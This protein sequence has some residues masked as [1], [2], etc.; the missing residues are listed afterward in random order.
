MK[1]NGIWTGI[2]NID[3]WLVIFQLHNTRENN[4]FAII[5]MG[6]NQAMQS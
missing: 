3:P 2:Q 6:F 4:Y 5:Q 1:G